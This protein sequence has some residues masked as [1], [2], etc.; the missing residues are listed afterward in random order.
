MPDTNPWS[1]L[2]S[3]VLETLKESVRDLADVES[4]VVKAPLAEIAEDMAH[5]T[6]LSVEGTGEERLQAAGNLRSL[7]AQATIVAAR[8]V[9][10]GAAE[11]RVAF[12][13]AIETAGIFLLKNAP[14]LIAAL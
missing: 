10:I 6:W 1:G 7:R 9:V 12:V 3:G 14:A 2:T 5:Q 11:L 13:K 8:A 4:D